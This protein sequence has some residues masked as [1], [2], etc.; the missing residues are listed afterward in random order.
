M[1]VT[2]NSLVAKLK[3]LGIPIGALAVF[4]LA[5]ALVVNH[6]SALAASNGTAMLDAASPMDDN[7]V[8]SLVA[9]D[10]SVEAVAARVTPAVVN[11]SVTARASAESNDDD[12]QDANGIPPGAIPP[13]FRK[14][15]GNGGHGMRVAPPNQVERGIGSGIIISPEGY[16][17][18]N[19]HVAGGA[20]QIRVTLN[21]RRVF[22]AKLVGEDKLNDLAVIKIDGK[23]LTSVAWGLAARARQLF[24]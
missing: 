22:P 15:F 21:D 19:D 16:I 9:L 14:F 11:V 3:K 20:T 4:L 17:V 2:T 7:S 1:P 18:T 5:F 10:N 23:N 12:D 24:S 8:S 13:E 6:N